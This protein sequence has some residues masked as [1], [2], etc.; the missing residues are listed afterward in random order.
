[1]NAA[2]PHRLISDPAP[3]P[4]QITS[5]ASYG[6]NTFVIYLKD[7]FRNISGKAF[8][9]TTG[10]VTLLISL[11]YTVGIETRIRSLHPWPLSLLIFFLF[12]GVV[13]LTA[14]RIQRPRMPSAIDRAWWV[15]LLAP[16]FFAFKMIHWDFSF[17]AS[18]G[19]HYPWGRYTLVIMQL[20]MKLLVLLVMLAFCRKMLAGQST[21]VGVA[22][23]DSFF[24]FTTRGFTPRPYLLI[25]LFLVPVIALASTQ[26][27]FL[28]AY[29]KVK[30][31]AFINGYTRAVWPW[32]LLFEI[33]Y[34]LDFVSIELFFRGF[35]VIGLVRWA[36]QAAG[37]SSDL[38]RQGPHR[39]EPSLDSVLPMAAFYCTVHFGKPLG[40][41]ISSYFGGLALGVIAWR[42]RSVLG[43]LIVHLG[44]AWMME[45]GGWIG[46]L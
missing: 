37:A 26:H 46:N 16:L 12:Y 45:V 7:Y 13:F 5:S 11:N 18:A 22:G 28:L 23:D 36:G 1:V 21:G 27:D 32:K 10:F 41:C 44:L 29:P 42:T 15:L 20:P 17:L 4:G 25:L 19:W 9:L 43:G 3:G 30:N 39:P 24:G 38:L 6:L 31:I 14:W 34:G 2:D 8:L 35:L 40:E 33:S